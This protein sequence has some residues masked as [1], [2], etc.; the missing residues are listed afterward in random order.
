MIQAVDFIRF[1][2]KKKVDEKMLFKTKNLYFKKDRI[3]KKI[4]FLIYNFDLLKKI[5]LPIDKNLYYSSILPLTVLN[6]NNLKKYLNIMTEKNIKN[7][8]LHP[9]LQNIDDKKINFLCKKKNIKL[10]DK[11]NFIIATAIGTKKMYK[12]NPLKVAFRISETFKNNKI[13]L[14]HFG[15]F[16]ILEAINLMKNNKNIYADMS[17]SHIFWK[18]TSF[19]I[20]LIYAINQFPNKIFYGSDFPYCSVKKSYIYL[21]NF[22]R[23]KKIKENIIKKIF[24]KNAEKFLK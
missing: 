16:K 18:N 3:F 17:F 5:D 4:N 11:F 22:L 19:E 14:S 21:M 24:F 15:G 1:P 12:N 8:C 13:V 20:D 10:F 6:Q 9:Y 7:I 2:L 23:K